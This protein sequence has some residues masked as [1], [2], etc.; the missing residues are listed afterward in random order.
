[1]A[2]NKDDYKKFLLRDSLESSDSDDSNYFSDSS[3]SSSGFS[4]GSSYSSQSYNSSFQSS[5]ESDSQELAHTDRA[6]EGGVRRAIGEELFQL[7]S[8]IIYMGYGNGQV[9]SSSDNG[10]AQK[11]DP[12]LPGIGFNLTDD[13][14]F[15]LDGKR[16]TNVADP[17]DP[18]DAATKGYVD[19]ENAKQDIAINSK[20][21]KTDVD[22]KNNQQDTAINKKAEKK[23][24]IF[25]DGIQSMKGNLDMKDDKDD[26]DDKNDRK[27]N[28]INLANETDDGDADNL[29]QLKSYTESHQNNYHLQPSFTFYKNFG[30]HAPLLQ[31]NIN[32]IDHNHRDLLVVEKES[33]GLGYGRE[34][35]VSLEMTN[36]LAAAVYKVIFETFSATIPTYLWITILNN[37]TVITQVYGDAN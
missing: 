11:G 8:L 25:R 6:C 24:V 15:D 18:K 29:A 14:N 21:E 31:R 7:K 3:Q 37:E 19:G 13:G 36:N 35:L 20:A 33:S 27:S 23:D 30:D 16:L 2:D 4:S 12:G 22:S 26:K 9:Q 28:I 1:M 32:I 10:K 5:S 34:D 17:T